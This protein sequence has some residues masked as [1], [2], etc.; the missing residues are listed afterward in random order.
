MKPV[1]WTNLL[2]EV[3]AGFTKTEESVRK[4]ILIYEKWIY[5]NVIGMKWKESS[6]V[7]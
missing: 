5:I 6:I 1:D 3:Q 4:T 7:N 2:I